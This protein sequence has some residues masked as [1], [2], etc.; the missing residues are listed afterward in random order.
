MRF[1]PLSAIDLNIL[2]D[3]LDQNGRT[4]EVFVDP[5]GDPQAK[6]RA[7][8]IRGSHSFD[9]NL[10]YLYIEIDPKDLLLVK[11]DIL[12]MGFDPQMK[13]SAELEYKNEFLCLHCDCVS[14][15][16]GICPKHQEPLVEWSQWVELK[17]EN[18]P[19]A[20]FLQFAFVLFI[21]AGATY[22]V[23]NR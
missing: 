3:T 19:L 10:H 9:G 11:K 8:R 12:K 1:G 17:K 23:W 7:K 4:Y 6:E 22:F 5:D 20:R 16:P 13:P 2:K 21:V 18:T 14:E 15:N